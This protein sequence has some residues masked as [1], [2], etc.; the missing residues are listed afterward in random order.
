MPLVHRINDAH[1]TKDLSLTDNKK[2]R[3]GFISKYFSNHS[4]LLA[5]E[6]IIRHLDRAKFRVVLINLDG[7][8][9]R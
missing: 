5:F 7:V 2:I 4:N 3:I 1:R 9:K 8:R 6:G